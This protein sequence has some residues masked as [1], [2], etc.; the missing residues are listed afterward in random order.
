MHLADVTRF[1][2]Y[3]VCRRHQWL[4]RLLLLLRLEHLKRPNLQYTRALEWASGIMQ[5][6]L[7]DEAIHCSPTH[8]PYLL[9]YSV[10]PDVAC[11]HLYHLL[12]YFRLRWRLW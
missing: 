5:H 2:L 6:Y 3:Y 1:D 8:P 12:Q 4:L 10:L 11:L 9:S 7:D